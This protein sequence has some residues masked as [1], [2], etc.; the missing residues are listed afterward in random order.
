MLQNKQA[1]SGS[2]FVY[3]LV[4]V[5][6]FSMVM[7]AFTRGNN[8]STTVMSK[9]QA[10]TAA[11]EIVESLKTI[12]AGTQK[13]ISKGCSENELDFGNTVWQKN[14]NAYANAD[15]S[16]ARSDGS[17]ALFKFSG[18][19]VTPTVF[20]NGMTPSDGVSTSPKSGHSYI[21]AIQV[22]GFGSDGASGTASANDIVLSNP[23]I[24]IDTCLEINK[25]TNVTNPSGSPPVGTITGST[26]NNLVTGNYSD[27]VVLASPTGAAAS[28]I[29]CVRRGTAP[30]TYNVFAVLYSR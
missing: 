1:Q 19:G 30:Y 17:C 29:F 13:L 4:G 21:R 6:L 26:V 15:N 24:N 2:V 5:I 27:S 10:K 28:G 23:S 18:A 11:T 7:F 8:T 20:T 3:I 25:I 14:D 12:Q 22:T 16:N 9:A